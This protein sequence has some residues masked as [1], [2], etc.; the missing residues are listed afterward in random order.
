[1][2][3]AAADEHVLEQTEFTGEISINGEPAPITFHV[4]VPSDCRVR[5]NADD[6]NAHAYLLAVRNQGRSGESQSEFF[7]SGTS[8]DGKA[9]SSEH[10]F[11]CGHGHNDSRRWIDLGA[12]ACK[13]TLPLE[14]CV[15]R[16]VLRR[17]FRSFRSFSNPVVQTGFGRLRVW[18]EAGEVAADDVSGGVALEAPSGDPSA[19][20]R[21]K[22]E[23]FL[24]HMHQGLA[25]AHGGRLQMPRLDYLHLLRAEISFFD[26]AGFTPEF[27]VQYHLNHG[28]FI[29]ALVDRY[30]EKGSLPDILWTALGW[31]QTDT[32][33]DETRFLSSMTALEAIIESQLPERRGTI[34]PRT[35]FRP[36]R[37]RL[38][39]LIEHDETVPG[40]AKEIFLGNVA[41]LNKKVFAQKICALFD[42]YAIARTDF[43]GDVIL[44]LVK[45]RNDIV[46]RGYAKSCSD[47]WPSIIL[48]RELIT[49]I[50]LKEIGFAGRYCC[51]VGGLHDRDFPGEIAG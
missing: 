3:A 17:W 12:H 11:V 37:K 15:E 27:P 38:Q 30:D 46:H 31:M 16:P 18:G 36:L 22:A 43:E 34:I 29:E 39:I 7:L 47:L 21:H 23:D 5:I 20:W 45:L 8:V 32:T 2:S 13:I 33:F 25:L 6:V 19:G 26:G 49:R 10:V 48:V 1:M 4:S 50:L 24:T 51:Y 44:E 9:I 14:R 35:D 28:P 41:G 40:W 42:H